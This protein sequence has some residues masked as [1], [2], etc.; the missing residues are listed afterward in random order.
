MIDHFYNWFILQSPILQALLGGLFT[1]IL[2]A[3]GAGLVFI[4]KS[5]GRK[6]L[7]CSLG[8]TGGNDCS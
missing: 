1:W 5:S 4:F 3:L 7:D 2:T 6:F 8:F